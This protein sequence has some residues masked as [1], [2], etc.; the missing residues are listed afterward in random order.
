MLNRIQKVITLVGATTWILSGCGLTTTVTTSPQTGI[1]TFP[2]TQSSVTASTTPAT[3]PVTQPPRTTAA[4]TSAP[5]TTTTKTTAPATK[6]PETKNP[7]DPD[8]IKTGNAYDTATVRDWMWNNEAAD[9]Y[10]DQKLVFLTFDDG[11][12]TNITPK[13]LDVLEEN[14]V[15]GTFFYYTNGDLS[16]RAELIRRTVANGNAIAIH[17]NSHNYS[18]L[19]PKRRA[20]V[21]AV[22]EDARLA[23]AKIKAILGESWTTGVYRF[24]GGSFSWTGSKSARSAMTETKRALSAMGLEYL[25]WN[26]L[27]GDSDLNNKDKSADG[28]VKYAIKTTRNATGHVIVLLMH[29]AGHIT[30]GPKALQ[31]I[32]DYYKAEGYE[33]GILK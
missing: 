10:P 26:A 21:E 6:P 7:I 27:S 32:I 24:P 15:Q 25:D 8:D 17:T 1:L 22:L 28:L 4:A 12:S 19:Y 3:T 14:N 20:N 11:P 29:D 16:G 2:V 9:Y 18:L 23:L 33:F 5:A 30:N 31:G 13:I